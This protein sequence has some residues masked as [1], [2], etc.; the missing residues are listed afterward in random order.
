MFGEKVEGRQ[1][2]QDQHH[3]RHEGCDYIDP[4][5][6]ICKEFKH[7]NLV[8]FSWIIQCAPKEMKKSLKGLMWNAE[9]G[10]LKAQRLTQSFNV[11]APGVKH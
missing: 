11:G 7:N 8:L 6:F 10:T 9:R 1:H 4:K 5:R 2:Q 3:A